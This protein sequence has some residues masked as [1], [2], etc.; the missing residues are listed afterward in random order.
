M[1]DSRFWSIIESAWRG[2]DGQDEAR[3][4]LAAG[5]LSEDD[6]DDLADSLADFTAALK[7]QLER[8]SADELLAF[9]RI[10]ER[11]FY[12]IDRADIHEYT[13]GSDDGFLYARGF[14]VAAGKGYYEA[15]KS[16]PSIAMMDL[17]CEDLCFM[18]SN[19][20]EERFG[21]IPPSG[22]SIESCSNKAGWPDLD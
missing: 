4:Q 19:L 11:K 1:D 10:L 9:D 7:E 15:V 17:E 5:E 13:G 12:D 16:E 8:L 6:A 14:I 20:Y 22:L 3:R 2:I 21:E 18:A